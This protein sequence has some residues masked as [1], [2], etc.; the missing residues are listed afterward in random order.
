MKSL[1][2]PAL[3]GLAHGASDAVAGFLVVQ[4]LMLSSHP[5]VDYIL[6]YNMLAFGLQPVV[7][8]ILDTYNVPRRAASIGLFL[9]ALSLT[10]TW[11][12]LTWGILLAGL[13]SAVFH[14]G[15]G[16]VALTSTPSRAAGPAV[17]TAFGVI[18]L[19]IGSQLGFYFSVTTIIAFVLTLITLAALL[20]FFPVV[21]Q[22]ISSH[23]DPISS[24]MSIE[25]LAFALVLAVA[26]RSIVWTGIQSSE[27][28]YSQMALLIA[29]AAGLG[30]LFG[31]FAA[32]RFGW[33][34]YTIIAM[35]SSIFLLAFRAD[36]LWLLLAGVFFLQ[37]VTPLSL[38]AL[39]R[40]MPSS[41]ALAASL[42]L[43]VAVLLGGFPLMFA[44]LNWLAS[45]LGIL[46]ILFASG[47]IYLCALR[48]I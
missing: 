7:G 19:A 31:G 22:V 30:K 37:S 45:P 16:S 41:P 3:T 17:F 5:V 8:L 47:G 1:S 25:L 27:A 34:R 40:R 2:L 13:G 18:G 12:S 46:L 9:S 36:T 48:K 29:L 4:V 20:W 33:L 6:F 38:A 21:A 26:L 35:L 39:G 11:F 28:G 10:L 24:G 32:D 44:G 23:P 15:G 14:A 43:G 42:V